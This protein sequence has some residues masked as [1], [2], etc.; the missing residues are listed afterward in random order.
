M[1]YISQ[2]D[3]VQNMT[4]EQRILVAGF[5]AKFDIGG[6]VAHKKILKVEN[7]LYQGVTA[8]SEFVTYAATK[9]YLN[10]NMRFSHIDNSNSFLPGKVVFYDETGAIPLYTGWLNLPEY[11]TAIP[12]V[13]YCVNPFEVNNSWFS[14][15]EVQNYTYIKFIGYRITLT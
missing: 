8:G 11:T 12:E 10:L 1:G 2:P 3:L 5:Y 9:L 15:I 4:P 6:G 13:D 7:F 14:M